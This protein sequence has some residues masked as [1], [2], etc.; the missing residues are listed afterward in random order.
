MSETIALI[1][2]DRIYGASG[3]ELCPACLSALPCT[4]TCSDDIKA[5]MRAMRCAISGQLAAL[6]VSIAAVMVPRPW[7]R[8]WFGL[9]L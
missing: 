2:A 7:W 8:R 6:D 9:G 4:C 1:E 5:A 3:A